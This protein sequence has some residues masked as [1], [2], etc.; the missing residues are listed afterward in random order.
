MRV[1]HTEGTEGLTCISAYFSSRGHR[2]MLKQLLLTSLTIFLM[3]IYA[4]THTNARN[5]SAYANWKHTAYILELCFHQNAQWIVPL[6]S[7]MCLT[8]KRHEGFRVTQSKDSERTKKEDQRRLLRAFRNWLKLCVILSTRHPIS[9]RHCKPSCSPWC[10]CFS[11]KVAQLRTP[12]LPQVCSGKGVGPVLPT[13]GLL[14]SLKEEMKKSPEMVRHP[15]LTV[16]LMGQ[17]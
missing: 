6:L 12:T 1:L 14:L 3:H 8:P 16:Q 11:G 17:V 13:V 15:G 5:V 7:G 2:I 10:Q 9:M 4:R